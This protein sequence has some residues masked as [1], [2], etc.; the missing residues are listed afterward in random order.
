MNLYICMWTSNVTF[1]Q[2]CVYTTHWANA[3]IVKS[4]QDKR[5][6][7]GVTMSTRLTQKRQ[8]VAAWC[9]RVCRTAYSMLAELGVRPKLLFLFFQYNSQ[10]IT[11]LHTAFSFD[12]LFLLFDVAF[13]L[14]PQA[15]LSN[16]RACYILSDEHTLQVNPTIKT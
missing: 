12:S 9:H 11:I 13:T 6:W 10:N 1:W 16:F 2:V 15:N 3:S 4:G 5:L 14:L 8:P 7:E